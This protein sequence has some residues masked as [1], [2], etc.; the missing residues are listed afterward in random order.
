MTSPARTAAA[1]R[2]RLS[3]SPRS[4]SRE[5]RRTLAMTMRERYRGGA[6][7]LCRPRPRLRPRVG[8]GHQGE[9]GLC[10]LVAAALEPQA[11]VVALGDL[12]GEEEPD[13]E[14][15]DARG[16][17]VDR[18]GEAL[19]HARRVAGVEADAVVADG[20]AHEALDLPGGHVHAPA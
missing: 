14:P 5:S 2:E 1:A 3:K 9:V 20:D 10:P 17:G 7:A 15:G 16:L 18:P 19:E 12:V 4:A 13:A 8:A 11:A 6:P